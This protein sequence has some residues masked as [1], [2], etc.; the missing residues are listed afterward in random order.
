MSTRASRSTRI[1]LNQ[2]DFRKLLATPRPTASQ[3]QT[4]RKRRTIIPPKLSKVAPAASQALSKGKSRKPG[5]QPAD[6]A[7]NPVTDESQTYRDRA[8]ERRQAESQ[9][10]RPLERQELLDH[11]EERDVTYEQSKYLGG[12]VD[13][14][15][16]VKGLDYLLLNKV[17]RD[18]AQGDTDHQQDWD[19]TLESLHHHSNAPELPK[20]EE[21]A[22]A[23]PP[24]FL[25]TQGA[26]IYHACVEWLKQ[27][28]QALPRHNE[29][30][31]PG[32]L[33]FSFELV[34]TQGQIGNP[35]AVPTTIHR[36]KAD[37]NR[38]GI[39]HQ[40]SGEPT[41]DASHTS[42]VI[43]NKVTQLL[44]NRAKRPSKAIQSPPEPLAAPA[45]PRGSTPR[46]ATTRSKDAAVPGS[47]ANVQP[48][49][50]TSASTTSSDKQSTGSSDRSDAEST[51][52]DDED[53]DI[54]AGVGSNYTVS[55]A[56]APPTIRPTAQTRIVKLFGPHLTEP[57]DAADHPTADPAASMALDTANATIT[58]L[59]KRKQVMR[60]EMQAAKQ[61]R[62]EAKDEPIAETTLVPDQCSGILGP[63]PGAQRSVG[64]RL[65]NFNQADETGYGITEELGGSS[66]DDNDSDGHSHTTRNGVTVCTGIQP[67]GVS[68]A[69][70][71]LRVPTTVM[72]QG[73]AKNKR[74]Q[75]SRWDFDTL[76]EWQHYKE[77]QTALPKAAFQYGVKVADGRKRSNRPL[78]KTPF[79]PKDEKAK[80]DRDLLKIKRIMGQKYQ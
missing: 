16:L 40:S 67:T 21:L 71:T 32:R 24:R 37:I 64:L 62:L 56:R 23:T 60:A 46:V 29:A 54:F 31:F 55:A 11:T 69:P 59:E 2:D 70:S 18:Q 74:A 35:F 26:A 45:R 79:K 33:L 30:F 27:Y 58:R 66:S 75:L 48:I 53:E 38:L 43:T 51:A 6:R 77:Q 8:A 50:T 52:S 19:K 72:D 78:A 13:H 14:T 36:S 68:E 49:P 20:A 42:Q 76:E 15:H 41:S 61:A 44:G 28:H 80:L 5:K 7:A 63:L 3:A 39:F 10:E 12:D 22:T 57:L 17:R 34:G 1:R 73:T 65:Q 47:T 9:S 25:T 4:H